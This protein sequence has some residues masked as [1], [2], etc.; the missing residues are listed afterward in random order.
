MR[1]DVYFNI[2]G[3]WTL[4]PPFLSVSVVAT[5]EGNRFEAVHSMFGIRPSFYSPL[6]VGET[7]RYGG[8]HSFSSW[9]LLAPNPLT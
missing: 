3:S 1:L 4:S 8:F 9:P 6:L 2:G 7:A 5:N